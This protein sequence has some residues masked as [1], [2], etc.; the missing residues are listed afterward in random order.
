MGI[1]MLNISINDKINVS[2]L[3]KLVDVVKIDKWGDVD[4]DVGPNH[5]HMEISVKYFENEI[6]EY[7]EKN[8]PLD[9][10]RMVENYEVPSYN[11]LIGYKIEGNSI[12]NNYCSYEV[13]VDDDGWLERIV[14]MTEKNCKVLLDLLLELVS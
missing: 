4:M 13:F 1:R 2:D 7:V 10:K 11:K 12:S 3:K 8:H 14:V 9:V 6:I 5:H